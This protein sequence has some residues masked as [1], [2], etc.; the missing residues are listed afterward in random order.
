MSVTP[1]PPAPLPKGEGRL[2]SSR[3]RVVTTT[4]ELRAVLE[5]VRRAG[6]I[7]LVPTM[8]ALHD[9]H[10][11]L[12]R[13]AKAE[14]GF[15]VV[16]IY[17][18]PSQFGPGEDYRRYPRTL[19]EDLEKL[20]TFGADLV[21]APSSEEVYPAGY[22]TWVEV[23][24][25]AQPL[26]GQSRP[27]HFRGVATIVLKLLNM[28]GADVAYFGQKDYQQA[29]VVRRMV[30]DLN[31][32]IAIRVCPTVREPDGLAMSSRNAY[33][34]PDAR[35]HALVL[36]RSLKLAAK[37]ISE[38]QRDAATIARRMA[39]LIQTVPDARIDYVALVDPETLEPVE[40]IRGRTLA[41]VAVVIGQTRLIDNCLLEVLGLGP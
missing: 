6:K 16:T 40:A 5:P 17:V 1:S 10:L 18:N 15:T 31:V 22:G 38:G 19:D 8:G 27:V 39:E 7:G 13:A 20:A 26:E 24:A 14:C 33:L 34:G 37:L 3:P 25:I 11:S 35:Q 30:E 28:V 29:L 21:F 4:R 12:V 32:P 9:G 2:F 23:G 36:S 41:A